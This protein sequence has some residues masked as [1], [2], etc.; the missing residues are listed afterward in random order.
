MSH[1]KC[2]GG[3]LFFWFGGEKKYIFMG[4]DLLLLYVQNKIF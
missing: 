1:V 2:G 3:T 4:Q